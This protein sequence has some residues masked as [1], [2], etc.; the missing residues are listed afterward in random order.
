MG[1]K[2]PVIALV[3]RTYISWKD[4]G[5]HQMGWV[6]QI[7]VCISALTFVVLVIFGKLSNFYK[8]T[9]MLHK[10]TTFFKDIVDI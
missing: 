2:N 7:K 1:G 5:S 10:G 8:P 9:H 4:N 3:E 6:R